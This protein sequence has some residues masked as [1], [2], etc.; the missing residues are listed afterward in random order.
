M[1]P[2]SVE[3]DEVLIFI[4][5]QEKNFLGNLEKLVKVESGILEP[6]LFEMLFKVVEG[7]CATYCEFFFHP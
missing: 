6:E 5:N 3:T 4:L 2:F 7:D 1:A